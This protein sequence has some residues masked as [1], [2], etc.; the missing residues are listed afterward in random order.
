M[1]SNPSLIAGAALGVAGTLVLVFGLFAAVDNRYVTRREYGA[2]L[3]DIQRQLSEIK[4]AVGLH[5]RAG[6]EDE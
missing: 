5:V 2:T 6:S 1:E 4:G 3:K